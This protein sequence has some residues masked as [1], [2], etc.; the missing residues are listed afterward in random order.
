MPYY[1]QVRENLTCPN[2][3]G[4]IFWCPDARGQLCLTTPPETFPPLTLTVHNQPPVSIKRLEALEAHRYLGVHIATNGDHG[5][6]LTMFQQCNA[7][8]IGLLH[9]CPFP[10][11]DVTVIY[12]QCYLPMVSY[13]LPA[14][15]MPVAKLYKI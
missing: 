3:S 11:Q 9:Q 6:E 15:S 7:R 14:T 10:H 1:K 12:K 4:S 8:F 5:T 2:V 13:P